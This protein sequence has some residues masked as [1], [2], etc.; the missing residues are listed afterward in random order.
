MPAAPVAKPAASLPLH[1]TAATPH[2]PALPVGVMLAAHPG[3]DD[4]LF[5]LCAQV[6]RA[7]PWAGT[8]PIIA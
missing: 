3:R 6:E 2:R 1:V 5:S 8:L 4:V 7:A